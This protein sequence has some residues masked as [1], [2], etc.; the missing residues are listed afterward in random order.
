MSSRGKKQKPIEDKYHDADGVIPSNMQESREKFMHE[1]RNALDVFLAQGSSKA[2]QKALERSS[3]AHYKRL[4]SE[5]FAGMVGQ[6]EPLIRKMTFFQLVD[7][8]E[9]AHYESVRLDANKE[10]ERRLDKLVGY[11]ERG[12]EKRKAQQVQVNI[13]QVVDNLQGSTLGKAFVERLAAKAEGAQEVEVT[14]DVD[15]LQAET[16]KQE[17]PRVKATSELFPTLE[18]T[19]E[20]SEEEEREHKK[21]W[22]SDMLEENEEI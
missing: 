14:P 7:L 5:S 8:M 16:E 2:A 13:L 20:L 9:N 19:P 10:I 17:P 15:S 11:V 21:E 1:C 6:I 12:E 3:R 4:Y 18:T 22:L